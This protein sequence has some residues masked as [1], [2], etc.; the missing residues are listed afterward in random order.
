MCPI[1][2]KDLAEAELSYEFHLYDGLVGFGALDP[3]ARWLPAELAPKGMDVCE[4][5][6]PLGDGNW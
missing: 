5:V 6:L 1:Q 3:L 2:F 4:E